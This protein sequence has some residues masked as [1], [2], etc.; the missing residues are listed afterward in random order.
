MLKYKPKY[1]PAHAE[2]AKRLE[3]IDPMILPKY[4]ER[5]KFVIIRGSGALKT[6]AI[7]VF[8]YMLFKPRAKLDLDYY[9]NRQFLPALR[10]ILISL[11]DL[12]EWGTVNI[13]QKN[14]K[15]SKVNQHH[16]HRP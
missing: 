5:L 12:D 15:K 11:V 4:G 7:P 1:L 13:Y 16:R 8:E 3:L 9:Y 6:R 10:R 2:A 14:K